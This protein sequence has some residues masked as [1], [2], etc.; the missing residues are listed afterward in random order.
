L[1]PKTGKDIFGKKSGLQRIDRT[2]E[3]R[4]EL[5]NMKINSTKPMEYSPKNRQKIDS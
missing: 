4:A 2:I 5:T 3:I 1:A